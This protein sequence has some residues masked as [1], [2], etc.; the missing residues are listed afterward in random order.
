MGNSVLSRKAQ[1]TDVIGRHFGLPSTRSSIN[2]F[3]IRDPFPLLSSP[4]SSVSPR[5]FTGEGSSVS[6]FVWHVRHSASSQKI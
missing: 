1:C 4:S 3:Y 6:I 5:S 2:L